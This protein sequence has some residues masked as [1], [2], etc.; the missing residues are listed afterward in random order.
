MGHTEFKVAVTFLLLPIAAGCFYFGL[1]DFTMTEIVD[2]AQDKCDNVPS[3]GFT[4]THCMVDYVDS[5]CSKNWKNEDC[6]EYQ[7]KFL[8]K[9]SNQTKE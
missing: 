4:R 2:M 3:N 6:H 1:K 5:Y 9:N 7:M 8:N